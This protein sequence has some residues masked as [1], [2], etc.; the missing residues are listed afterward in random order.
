MSSIPASQI[1]KEKSHVNAR[2]NLQDVAV[3]TMSHFSIQTEYATNA[4]PTF[5]EI[6][7]KTQPH[8]RN[9]DPSVVNLYVEYEVSDRSFGLISRLGYH[10]Y[11]A[12]YLAQEII[13]AMKNLYNIQDPTGG[14]AAPW[15]SVRVFGWQL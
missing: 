13:P 3:V 11:L 4:D 5:M 8:I 2:N 12:D 7:D 1:K 14:T 9:P 10:Q 6:L 15:D